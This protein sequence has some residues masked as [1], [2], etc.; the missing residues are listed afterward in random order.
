MCNH[1]I[2][3]FRLE[4]GQNFNFGQRL[5]LGHVHALEVLML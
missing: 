2:T 5:S 4:I 1:E 3:D